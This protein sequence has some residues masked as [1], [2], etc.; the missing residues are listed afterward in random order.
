M[1]I[2]DV[3]H[4]K[5]LVKAMSIKE[6]I[7]YYLYYYKTPLLIGALVLLCG[8]VMLDGI[9]NKKEIVVSAKII[10]VKEI[11]EPNTMFIDELSVA[12][13]LDEETQRF[14]I[15]VNSYLNYDQ[16]DTTHINQEIQMETM[17]GI[18]QLDLIASDENTFRHI[19]ENDKFHDL[20]DVLSEEQIALY[21]PYFYYIDEDFYEQKYKDMEDTTIYYTFPEYNP[22]SKEGMKS[23]MAIGIYVQEDMF[24]LDCYDLRDGNVVVGL[25][26][27]GERL[28]SALT[29]LDVM[30]KNE[31]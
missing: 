16:Q 4:R 18:G 23:P 26:N 19:A 29:C 5:E 7:K 2:K 22:L 12:T 13:G 15:D 24:L 21:E 1:S 27:T 31:T 10:N 20:Y 30:L 3:E 28:E 6:K 11:K 17:M 14:E 25:V 8:S 9:I